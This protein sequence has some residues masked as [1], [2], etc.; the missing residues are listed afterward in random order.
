[1]F[2]IISTFLCLAPSPPHPWT[3][4]FIPNFDHAFLDLYFLTNLHQTC[5][6]P[7]RR[8]ALPCASCINPAFP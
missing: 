7:S 3:L 6:L 1:M 4:V 2:T 5:L 8:V